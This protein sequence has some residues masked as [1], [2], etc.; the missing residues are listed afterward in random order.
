LFIK[1]SS[2]SATVFYSGTYFRLLLPALPAFVIGVACLPLLV[3]RAARTVRAASVRRVVPHRRAIFAAAFV[4]FAVLPAAAVAAF[5]PLAKPV[6]VNDPNKSRLYPV[7][8]DF[9]L[10]ATRVGRQVRLRWSP[11]SHGPL[12]RYAVYRAPPAGGAGL[13]CDRK[14]LV[15]TL[16]AMRRGVVDGRSFAETPPAGDWAY[17]V[18]LY[19]RFTD[20][21]GR[22]GVEPGAGTVVLLS[23]PVTVAVP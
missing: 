13:V 6:V 5:R 21:P 18:G 1:G 20:R 14:P 17:R 11:V 2:K 4:V 19:V 3:P 15:C 16:D 8:G 22:G 10:R 12:V 23:D 9:H 7:G